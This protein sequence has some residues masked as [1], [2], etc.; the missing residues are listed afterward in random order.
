MPGCVFHLLLAAR[1]LDPMRPCLG[2]G[3]EVP[4]SSHPLLDDPEC[5]AA[6][7]L[8][9]NGPDFGYYPGGTPLASDLAHYV[10]TADLIRNLSAVAD[11]RLCR[12]FVAGWLSHFLGDCAVHPLVNQGVGERLHGDRSRAVAYA[13]APAAHVRVELGLD[14][15]L[16]QEQEDAI[17]ELGPSLA[18]GP[19][20][21]SRLGGFLAEAYRMT[22]GLGDEWRAVERSLAALARGVPW[23][24]AYECVAAGGVGRWTGLPLRLAYRAARAATWFWPRRS[25]VRAFLHPAPPPEWLRHAA[26]ARLAALPRRIADELGAGLASLPN[27]NLDTGD[28]EAESS[29]YP[30]AVAARGRLAEVVSS[31]VRGT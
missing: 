25:L 17:R 27:S 24:V 15:Q 2:G 16:L 22:Y 14:V 8:G 12:A 30:L 10:G 3:A 28:R 23:L 21:A 7:L 31:R 1:L 9:A 18:A 11:D 5:R 20:V 13:D 29:D 26:R 19:D 4:A 6:A